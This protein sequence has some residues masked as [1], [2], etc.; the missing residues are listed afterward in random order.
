MRYLLLYASDPDLAGEWSDD[1]H[2]AVI[3]WIED[4]VRTRV[5][6]HGS[7]LRFSADATTVKI[8]GGELITTDG[9]FA[10]T[11]EQIVGYDLIECGSR[12]EA[13]RWAERN[14]HARAG[15][16]DVRALPEDAPVMPLPEPAAGKLRYLMFVGI[17]P[18][19]DP[20]EPGADDS[21]EPWVD[22]W[23]GRGVRLYGSELESP[24]R[25][26]TVQV[27]DSRAL[28]TDG[29]FA[30][31]KEQIVGFDILECTDLDEA[32]EVASGHPMARGGILEVRP[33][34]PNKLK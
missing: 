6:L 12:D 15:S 17:D 26:T 8:R 22:K 23:D 7:S 32:I 21:V 24:R 2:A 5:S 18:G 25:A 31:T 20:Q 13:L 1:D 4:A 33:F 3:D 14:P 28:V 29:P 30:E 27:R 9:P 34:W 11:K 19:A 10:E 16:V